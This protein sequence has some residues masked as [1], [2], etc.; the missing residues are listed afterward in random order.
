MIRLWKNH[1]VFRERLIT[2]QRAGA[3]H[4][5]MAY[6]HTFGV[7]TV[8]SRCSNNFGPYQFPEKVIPLFVTNALE[9]KPLPL[10][11]SSLNRRE[12]VYVTDHCR[13]IA[14]MITKGITGNVYN[15]GT[16]VEKTVEDL[17]VS[18]LGYLGLPLTM[19]MYVSDRPGH[20][21]RYLLDSSK[22]RD[23]LG[24]K[25]L[26]D[27]DQGLKTTIKWYLENKQW[28]QKLKERNP[29]KEGNW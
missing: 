27:F 22:I 19:K 20:D 18:I 2:P 16:G 14:L 11:Q 26:M 12:W 9:D 28:W 5:V 10:Y 7:P 4:A 15:V 3:D 25:P 8:I 23:Q 17:S 29:V 21:R 24:W 1:P 13:A 6:Y